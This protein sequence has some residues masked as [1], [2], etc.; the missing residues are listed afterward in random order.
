MTDRRSFIQQSAALLGGLALH[1]STSEAFG[2]ALPRSPFGRLRATVDGDEEEF[3]RQ[4]R[5]AYAC[6]PTLINLNN[7]GVSPSPRA[8]IA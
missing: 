1:Q 7:G 3:W 6:S 5:A 2:S 4:I 8:A